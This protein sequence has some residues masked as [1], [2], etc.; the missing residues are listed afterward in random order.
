[1]KNHRLGVAVE[2]ETTAT[3]FEKSLICF[4]FNGKLG[5]LYS[6]LTTAARL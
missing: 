1:M 4:N 6:S 5:I 3:I 2:K